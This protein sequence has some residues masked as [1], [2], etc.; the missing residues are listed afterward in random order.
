[1]NKTKNEIQDD[2]LSTLINFKKCTA[3]ISM[4]VGKT[5]IGLRYIENFYKKDIKILVVCPKL[6]VMKSWDDEIIKFDK[7]YLKPNIEYVTWIS[8]CK[9]NPEDYDIIIL[10]EVHNIGEPHDKFLSKYQG[11]TLGLTGTP[12]LNEYSIK[13]KLINKHC[14]IVYRYELDNAISD[15]ILNDYQI[16]IYSID[17][18]IRNNIPI[19]K[20]DG[21][22]FYTSEKKQYE[23]W[24]NQIAE[25][26]GKRK[27]FAAI[28]RMRCMQNFKSK[29]VIAK[30]LLDNCKDKCI[31][32]AN[33]QNQA[34]ELC[35]R[36]FHSKNENSDKNLDD[37]KNDIITKLSCVEQLSES[38]NIPNLKQA[39]IMHF[40]SANSSRSKQKW[41]R[42][43]RLIVTDTG[44]L[45]IIC[46]RNTVDETWIKESLKNLNQTKINWI[47]E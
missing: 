14:P 33:T 24:T 9:K 36:S 28:S 10:E 7:E 32:F 4:G 30:K 46:F 31:L 18:D 39:I 8:L 21:S 12:P 23:Y 17:L 11:I 45:S 43:Y 34:D 41:G 25:S 2:A 42:I 16:N 47:N 37:F 38:I 27:Q 5:L 22:V 13:Y 26:S 35:S 15:N 44:I 1:M 6:K 3:A 29:E 40:Y 19:N 20:K